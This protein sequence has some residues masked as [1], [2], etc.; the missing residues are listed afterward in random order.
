MVRKGTRPP[1]CRVQDGRGG[2][3]SRHETANNL[4]R[5]RGARNSAT[6]YPARKPACPT[7][8]TPPATKTVLEV[9]V[10]LQEVLPKTKHGKSGG[11]K[12]RSSD[13]ERR[14]REA[15]R[16]DDPCVEIERIRQEQGYPE[17]WFEQIAGLCGIS[18]P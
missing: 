7:R 6:V 11:E 8:G 1:G 9:D 17:G 14:I 5:T 4:A 16:S 15:R 3:H 12:P 10:E 13:V 2:S 18:P